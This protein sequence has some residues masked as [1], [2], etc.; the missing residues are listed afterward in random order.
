L[1]LEDADDVCVEQ[2]GPSAEQLDMSV[3]D[4]QVVASTEATS[5]H[6]VGSGE[7]NPS[8]DTGNSRN[9][10]D[11]CCRVKIGVEAALA[12]MSCDFGQ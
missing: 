9:A 10:S 8:E 6:D 2:W 11:N 12:G 4:D 7:E 5:E 1:A 3:V